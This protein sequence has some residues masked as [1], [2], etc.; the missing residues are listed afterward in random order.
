MDI[1]ALLGDYTNILTALNNDKILVG[2]TNFEDVNFNDDL[3]VIDTLINTP[4]GKSKSYDGDLE[5]MTYTTKYRGI[6][7]FDFYGSSSLTLANMF[8]ARIQSQDGRE[9]ARDNKIEINLNS[10]LVNVANIQGVTI[11]DRYQIEIMV[12]YSEQYSE[13]ILRIDTAQI[14]NI[15]TN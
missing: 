6:F 13:S 2:R 11:Y 15:D 3:I 10:S 1:L 9:F 7:T 4:I 12:K 14:A 5:I 8:I